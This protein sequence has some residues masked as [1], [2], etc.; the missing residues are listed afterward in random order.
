MS[1]I[2]EHED[3]FASHHHAEK[4]TDDPLIR[5]MA[6][7]SLI[8]CK[9][10]FYLEEVEEIRVADHN[11]FSGRALHET[12]D[13]GSDIYTVELGSE[14]L[15]IRG[16]LDC[17]KR[18]SG[19]LVVYEHKKGKSK[20]GE[21]AW[22]S[23]R[24]QVLAYCLLLAE[25]T[26]EPVSEACIR[27]H[28]DNKTIRLSVDPVRV[29]EEVSKAVAR[30]KEIRALLT[31]PPITACETLCANCSLAPVC[32]PEETRFA[33][34]E[35]NSARRFFPESDDRQIIHIAEQGSTIHK[36][37]EQLVVYTP[38][39]KKNGLPGLAISALILH[40]NV[41]LSTQALHFCAAHDIS[42]HWLSFGGSYV[43][44]L[45][46]GAGNVQ[47]RNRQYQALQESP[48]RVRLALSLVQAKIENQLKYLLRCA[49]NRQDASAEAT[50]NQGI[51]ALRDEL[52][53]LSR[54]EQE[55]Q[56]T[57]DQAAATRYIDQIRGHE[58]RAGKEY[59]AVLPSLLNLA[60]NDLLYFHGRNRRPPKDPFNALL[61]F[62]YALLYRDCLAALLAVGLEPCLG[63]MHTPR[64]SACPLALDL[65]DLFRMILWDVPL[66]GSVN[67]KQWDKEDFAITSGQV[68]LNDRGRRKAIQLYESRKQ[69]KWK[70]PVLQYSL[71]Y[72]RTIELEARLLEKEWTD[73]QRL[74]AKLRL[75]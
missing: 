18:Q 29:E 27:Y 47:R 7:H 68:W 31:R 38:D 66:I 16:K 34:G 75:R 19:A 53:Q 67:R 59:F 35:K 74:F 4:T 25:H 71:S 44:C 17:A 54:L 64:S 58:G 63:F 39:G 13:K 40:G 60:P 8:Y 37:G 26:G 69:E 3:A 33:L 72:T 45:V 6:L 62:G 15:G 55:C 36:T 30:A 50:A 49:R 42:V 70:H 21:S 56:Q 23:D 24:L 46:T 5:V 11:V 73:N 61:S 14:R 2:A 22:P 1:E 28:A 10:L 43:G 48:L 32:L 52:K 57:L 12:L 20:D 51:A 9:R 41:Q 65:M